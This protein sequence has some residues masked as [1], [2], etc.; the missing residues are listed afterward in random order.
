MR[1]PHHF[2][3]GD[4]PIVSAFATAASRFCGVC[5]G[6]VCSDIGVSGASVSAS[7]GGNT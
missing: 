5:S 3:R 2:L 1:T 7:V 4:F 6:V